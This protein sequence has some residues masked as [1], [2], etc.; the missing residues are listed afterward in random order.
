MI[1]DHDRIGY[2]GAS[3]TKYVM[4][5]WNTKTFRDWWA[6]KTGETE[7]LLDNIYTRAGS[8]Y[9]GRILDYLEIDDRDRQIII[10]RLRVNLDGETSSHVVEIKTYQWLK[11]FR[12][13]KNVKKWDYWQQVQVEMFA[14]NKTHAFLYAYGLLPSEYEDYG[15][16]DGNRLDVYDFDYDEEWI[17]N[18]YLPR[19]NRLAKCLV[20]GEKPYEEEKEDT[21]SGQ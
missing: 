20:E 2:I 10:G 5:N 7:D 9:E 17:E 18:E 1:Q 19:L 14:T 4:G 11:G 3:D 13:P 12:I 21:D 6:V 15:E 16:V 8:A